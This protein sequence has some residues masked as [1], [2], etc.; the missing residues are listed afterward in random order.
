MNWLLGV[1][2]SLNIVFGILIILPC[3]MIAGMSGDN[4]KAAESKFYPV[5]VWFLLTLPVVFA[6]FG[7]AGYFLVYFGI[8]N[9][10]FLI[11]AFPWVWFF[12]FFFVNI[13]LGNLQW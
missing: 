8:I 10:G 6:G 1:F 4:P 13:M 12:C 7:I 5:L 3:L 9:W 2:S 11:E